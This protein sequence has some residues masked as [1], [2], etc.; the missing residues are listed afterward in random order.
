LISRGL[1]RHLERSIEI[2]EDYDAYLRRR[3]LRPDEDARSMYY[4]EPGR[5]SDR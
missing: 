3:G 4:R 5:P 1:D 2:I